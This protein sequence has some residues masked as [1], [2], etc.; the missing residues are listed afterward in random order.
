MAWREVIGTNQK[1]ANDHAS[2]MLETTE[3]YFQEHSL[4]HSENNRSLEQPPQGRVG[5]SI[6]GVFKMQLDRVL[7]DLI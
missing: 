6:T 4:H 7:D 5:V 1:H 3:V 2:L